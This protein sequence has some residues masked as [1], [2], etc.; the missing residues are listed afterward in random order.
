MKGGYNKFKNLFTYVY[1]V[2]DILIRVLEYSLEQ[3]FH[4]D[5]SLMDVYLDSKYTS[6]IIRTY[7]RF[8]KSRKKESFVFL[9][10]L[11]QPFDERNVSYIHRR[12]YYFPINVCKK[13]W[14]GVCVDPMCGKFTVLD[15]NTSFYSDVMM[16]K[17][18]HPHLAMIPHLLRLSGHALPGDE[19]HLLEYERPKCVSQTHNSFDS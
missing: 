17:H 15:C 19:R 2:V 7:P 11:V 1:Q 3:H 9:T 14:V 12:R 4:V 8:S 13:H 6:G 5:F 10:G 16:E 18:L